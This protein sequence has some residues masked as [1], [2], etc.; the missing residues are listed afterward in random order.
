[1]IK[2][3]CNVAD[4]NSECM[5]FSLPLKTFPAKKNWNKKLSHKDVIIN[6]IA[7]KNTLSNTFGFC[8]TNSFCLAK[9]VYKN[10][11]L[12]LDYSCEKNTTKTTRITNKCDDITNIYFRENA[13]GKQIGSP[14]LPQYCCSSSDFCNSNFGSKLDHFSPFK[15]L[16][17]MKEIKK[18]DG[19]TVDG[20][21]SGDQDINLYFH[22]SIVTILLALLVVLMFLAIFSIAYIVKKRRNSYIVRNIESE[23]LKQQNEK[24][25]F[26]YK[27]IKLFEITNMNEK[28]LLHH[29]C[30]VVLYHSHEKPK[31]ISS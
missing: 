21:G 30:I 1:M 4:K 25:I 5:M 14:R 16:N 13:R 27:V 23:N 2:C 29:T 11:T 17:S 12:G 20:S 24:L 3:V 9:S 26:S 8:H 19:N 15:L 31:I 28:G 10:D 22:T 6:R 18:I 7:K